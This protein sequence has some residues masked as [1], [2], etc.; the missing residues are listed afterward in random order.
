[1]RRCPTS[2]RYLP[3]APRGPRAADDAEAAV[4]PHR[5]VL[6]VSGNDPPQV[7]ANGLSEDN[8]LEAPEPKKP[9]IEEAEEKLD[10]ETAVKE[11]NGD[12]VDDKKDEKEPAKEPVDDGEMNEEA[13]EPEA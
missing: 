13:S 8:G 1:M 12:H 9:R 6:V 5:Q 10:T 2:W 7:T 4:Q 11:Q 3:P